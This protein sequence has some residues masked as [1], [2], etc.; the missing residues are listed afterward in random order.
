MKYRA[1]QPLTVKDWVSRCLSGSSSRDKLHEKQRMEYWSTFWGSRALASVTAE[2]IRQHR[3][4]MMASGD[5]SP[6]TVNRY[7]SAL[8]RMFTLACQENKIDRHP[9]KGLKFLPEPMK[10]RFFTDEELRHLQQLL[11]AQEWRTVAYA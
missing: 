8:R 3:A 11:P 4:V 1:Q 6:A 5:Y 2:D 9:M 7:C 10:D